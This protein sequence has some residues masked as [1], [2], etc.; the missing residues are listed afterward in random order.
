MGRQANDAG[1]G[2]A[3]RLSVYA[4]AGDEPPVVAV[5]PLEVLGRRLVD[6]P[7]LARAGRVAPDGDVAQPVLD[8]A[9]DLVRVEP[10][11][12]P[13]EPGRRPLARQPRADAGHPEQRPHRR[14]AAARRVDARP[15]AEVEGDLA[16]RLDDPQRL[17]DEREGVVALAVLQRDVAEGDVGG[18]VGDRQRAPVGD[19]D[20]AQPV[21]LAEAG[22]RLPAALE[23]PG[24][25][26]ARDDRAEAAGER[27]RHPAD[28]AA[29]LD[30][31]ALV[32]VAVEELEA[33]EVDGHLVVAG[34]DELGE[35]QRV[36][37]LVVEHPARRLDDFVGGRLLLR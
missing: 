3:W 25:E 35:R 13:G 12:L 37:R 10:V 4:D 7:Q 18:V 15:R 5:D 11:R 2:H 6:A 28:A 1:G 17:V 26:V 8:R 32:V 36:A 31:R 23:E 27:A 34:G 24:V 21:D 33:V 9:E 19:L 14:R 16:A 30:E 20:G 22:D 29:D